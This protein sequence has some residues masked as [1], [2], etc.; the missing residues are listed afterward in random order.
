MLTPEEALDFLLGEAR[1]LKDETDCALDDALGAVLAADVP[2]PIDLPGADLS[3]MDGYAV[4]AAD[5]FDA[6]SL[7]VAAR[8]VAGARE[9]APLPQGSAARIFT[10][11]PLPAGADTVVMQEECRAENDRVVFSRTVEVGSNV[12]RRASE[13]AQG[14]LLLA[15][16][17]R[18]SAAHIG[19]AASAG[20]ARLRCRRRLRVALLCT[21][22]ELAAPGEPLRPGQIY[23]ANRAQLAALLARLGCDVRVCAPVP[24]RLDTLRAAL[25]DAAARCD[26][27][28]TTG[29]VSVGEEDHVKAAVE[30]EGELRLW[31]IALKPGKPL[32]FGRVGESD[33]IGLPGN[34]VSCFVTFLLFVRPFLL[35]RMGAAQ[36]RARSL[37]L[38]AGFARDKIQNRTEYLRARLDD[39]GRVVPCAQQGSAALAALAAAD[40]LAVHPAGAAI[41]LN[42]TIEFFPFHALLS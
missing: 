1:P 16:G 4:R 33:F 22:D 23:N 34:P 37:R 20:I 41:A 24:D 25:K 40:G 7:P 21:G 12:R 18:I 28:L 6:A 5:T 19:L 31:K 2:C 13:M 3:A 8:I 39:E 17:T 38:P 9:C 29:G 11:A 35:A 10:G 27:L 15:G 30:A 32:A 14:A 36:P 42:E 26:V